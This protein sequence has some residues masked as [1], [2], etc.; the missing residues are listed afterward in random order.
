MGG[1][2]S[3]DDVPPPRGWLAFAFLGVWVYLVSQVLRGYPTAVSGATGL[4]PY[5]AF[6]ALA[7]TA[8]F[9]SIMVLSGLV[10]ALWR[11]NLAA[12]LSPAG[13][14]GLVLGA[15]GVGVLVL[16]LIAAALRLVGLEEDTL[17][18]LVR[19]Q[20]VGDVLGTAL[21]FAGLA[22]LAVGLTHAVGLFRAVA[23][24]ATA[25]PTAADKQA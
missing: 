14:R 11:A 23:P 17:T 22:S 15:A 16:F 9:G 18:A 7:V 24:E 20:P 5:V 12:G 1:S 10:A 4:D 13:V 6:Q 8:G 3:Y 25:T 19:A 21:A 2:L